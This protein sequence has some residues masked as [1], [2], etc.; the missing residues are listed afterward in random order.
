[1]DA[2]LD[3]DVIAQYININELL[4][5]LFNVFG[6]F[7]LDKLLDSVFNNVSSLSMID[8]V[9]RNF[10]MFDIPIPPLS[11]ISAQFYAKDLELAE[12]LAKA[13]TLF[14]V[15]KNILKCFADCVEIPLRRRAR[16]LCSD[17]STFGKVIKCLAGRGELSEE[18]MKVLKELHG[19]RS[20]R[21]HEGLLTCSDLAR[22]EELLKGLDGTE[23]ERRVGSELKECLWRIP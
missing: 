5:E 16:G 2:V 1:V 19:I 11:T 23:V 4:N 7:E 10:K 17:L 15:D 22:L 6:M 8:I 3:A 14:V 18:G 12:V 20:K 9:A 13:F 21:A